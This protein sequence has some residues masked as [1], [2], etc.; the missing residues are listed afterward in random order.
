MPKQKNSHSPEDLRNI[1]DYYRL[2]T[3]SIDDLVNAD[4]DN[5]PEVPP[6]ELKKYRSKSGIHLPTWL[7][8]VLLKDWFAGATCFFV[9]IGLGLY[10]N[11]WLDMMVIF[12]ISLGMVTD[13]LVNSILRFMAVVPGENDKWMLFPKRGV[14]AFLLNIVYG[15]VLLFLVDGVYELINALCYALGAAEYGIPLRVE[16]VLFGLFYM[17]FDLAFVGCR[18][19]M[20]RILLDARKKV[21]E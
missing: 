21:S 8:V 17:G 6:E 9:F 14:G 15:L 12:G 4:A 19:L 5:S 10:V 16:P 1:S 11:S 13:L 2:N 20:K 7:K 3:K 18:N